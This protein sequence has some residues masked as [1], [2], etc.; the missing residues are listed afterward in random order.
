M[1][2][3]D[4]T[5]NSRQIFE[6]AEAFCR[7]GRLPDAA[8]E[9]RS[10]LSQNPDFVPALHGLGRVLLMQQKPADA[11]HYLGHAAKGGPKQPQVLN[12]YAV[13]LIQSGQPDLAVGVFRQVLKLMPDN[14]EACRNLGLLLSSLR[15]YDEAMPV[16]E[17][18]VRLAPK[19]GAAH[20]LLGNTYC[21]LEH[22]PEALNQL[23]QAVQARPNDPGPWETIGAIRQRMGDAAAA[24]DAFEEAM[25][26]NPNV[27]EVL[28]NMGISLGSLGR[29][30][31]AR[32]ALIRALRLKPGVPTFLR[33]LAD[34]GH[35]T[36]DDPRL[37]LLEAGKAHMKAWPAADQVEMHLALAKAYDE[38]ERR[39][40]AMHHWKSANFMHRGTIAYNEA[41]ELRQMADMASVFT[42]EMLEK[43]AGLGAPSAKPVFIVGMP[44]SGTS[45]IEQILASHSQVFGAGERGDWDQYISAGR[46]GADFPAHVGDL[47]DTRWRD[48]GADY[49]AAQEKLAPGAARITDKMPL[50]FRWLGAIRLA[51]PN[52]KFIHVYRNPEDCALSCYSKTFPHGYGFIYDLEELGRYMRGYT[53]LMAHWKAVLPADCLM[54]V[55]YEDLVLKFEDIAREMVDFIGLEWQDAC[56]HFYQTKRPVMTA[57]SY[58]VRQ[59]ISARAIGR[60]Q[61]YSTWLAPFRNA[62]AGN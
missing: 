61:G 46:L 21:N 26:R 18:C 51:L 17:A 49:V 59:P 53:K 38:L 31:E 20:L 11:V 45:L 33:S 62:Y 48:L 36:P 12:D 32:D 4:Q 54:E 34:L 39:G 16:L 7:S 29:F 58:A 8:A 15:R 1:T 41:A 10:L 43:H 55:R 14:A 13:A 25:K 56:A 28:G 27:P 50:N 40:E 57:S 19:D 37:P 35:F 9:F 47:P 52:A 6:R 60:A 24:V 23:A 30:D 22:Y 5:Q 44:R 3:Q 42:R 2:Y